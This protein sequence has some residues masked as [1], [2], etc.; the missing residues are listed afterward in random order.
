MISPPGSHGSPP[1]FVKG[2]T[3]G[4]CTTQ[5]YPASLRGPAYLPKTA[6]AVQHLAA[7]QGANT[8]HPQAWLISEISTGLKR[9]VLLRLDGAPAAELIAITAEMWVEIVGENLEEQI[10]RPRVHAAFAQLLR[11]SRKWPQ[12]ADLL[13]ALPARIIPTDSK[14][15]EAPISDDQHARNADELRKIQEMFGGE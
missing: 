14:T 4:I 5:G 10:D 3:G 2:G 12:P 8:G 7:W 15:M 13:D 1:P 11:K 6:I 9:L